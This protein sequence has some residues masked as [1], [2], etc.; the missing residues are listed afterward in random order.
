MPK[1]ENIEL[2]KFGVRLKKFCEGFK[3][4]KY[5]FVLKNGEVFYSKYLF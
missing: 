4:K 1:E 3:N 5:R 2:I